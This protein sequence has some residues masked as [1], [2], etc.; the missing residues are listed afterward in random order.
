MG[1][2]TVFTQ[3]QQFGTEW[4]KLVT[5]GTNRF[6]AALAEVEKIEKQGVAQAASAV[7]EAGRVAKEAIN[8]GEQM[9]A[10]WRKAVNEY[11]QR[12]LELLTPKN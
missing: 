10:Q 4:L 9:S 7:D 1:Q 12:T 5:E 8:A 6:T 3:M 2:K 11:T